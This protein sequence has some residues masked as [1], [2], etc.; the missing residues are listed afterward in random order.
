MIDIWKKDMHK[1]SYCFKQFKSIKSLGL[2]I[3]II[4]HEGNRSLYGAAMAKPYHFLASSNS[5]KK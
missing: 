1:R 2:R 4:K 3:E 5:L